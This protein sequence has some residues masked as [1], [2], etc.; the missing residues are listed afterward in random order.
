MDVF[1]K[2][3]KDHNFV[4]DFGFF[5]DNHLQIIEQ[6]SS[7][8]KEVTVEIE[9]SN[10]KALQEEL[11]D[12]LHACFELIAFLGL[13]AK[14]T[15]ELSVAKAAIRY[16]MLQKITHEEGVACFANLPRETKLAY[17]EK[18]KQRLAS[19]LVE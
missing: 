13:D 3:L 16:E 7:E 12:V 17:W 4:N 18:A 14:E 6:I 8:L 19:K 5:W 1:E 10:R 15:L 11:G 9:Q 2:F